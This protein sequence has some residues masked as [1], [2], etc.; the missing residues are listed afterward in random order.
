M[1]RVLESKS[2]AVTGRGSGMAARETPSCGSG[3]I[4]GL[5]TFMAMAQ[6]PSGMTCARRPAGARKPAS[7]TGAPRKTEPR[8]GRSRARFTLLLPVLALLLGGLFLLAAPPAA[9]QRTVP[10]VPQNV[11][12]AVSDTAL[13]LTWQAPSS[14]GSF[15]AAGYEID[16]AEGASPPAHSS[17]DWKPRTLSVAAAATKYILTNRPYGTKYHMRIRAISANPGDPSDTLPSD[18]VVRSGTP[19][20]THGPHPGKPTLTLVTSGT[21]AQTATTLSFTVPCVPP[22]RAPVTDYVLRA[23]RTGS[24]ALTQIFTVPSPCHTITATLTGLENGTTY[25][26]RAFARNLRA[27]N[28]AWS[29]YVQ[30]TTLAL[31]RGGGG[32]SDPEPTDPLTASFEQVPSEHDG[33][34]A[35]SVL[36]RLSE[37]VGNFSKSPRASSFEVTQ[38]RV[39]S[40]KQVDAGL[41]RVRVKPSSWRAVTV[42]LAGGRDCDD[43]G[44]V[45]TRDG[46]ALT[47]T[48]SATVGDPVRIRL[49]GGRAREGRDAALGFAVTL[50]RAAAETVSVDYATADGTAV[51]GADYTAASGTLTFAP[52][53]T[54]KTVAVAILDDA[55]DEGKEKFYFRLSNPQGAHLRNMHREATGTVRNDD[56][57]QAM[58][59]S[60]FGRMVASDAVAALTARFETPRA[61]GSHLTMLGQRVNLSQDGDGDGSQAGAKALA[62]VLTGLAQ[63]FGAPNAPVGVDDD[64]FRRHGLSNSWSG[65]APTVAG[66][67]RVTGRD[68]LLGTSF[69]AVLPSGAGS[70]F[71]SW[72]QGASV[73]QFSAAVPG[74]GL[75]GET[76]TGSLGFDYEHGR[77]LTGLAMTHSVGEGTAH[78]GQWRYAMGSTVTTMLPFA[79]L[80]LS[81][82][83]SAWAMAGTGSGSLTLDLNGGVPQR[84]GTDLSMTLA[85]TGVRGELVKPAEAG[86]FA[87]ALKADA[88]WVRTESDRVSASGFGNL[89]AARG[90]SSRMRA[91]V[92]G[93]RTFALTGGA[94]LAPS[95]ELGL[96]HDGGDAETGTGMEFGAGLG[97]A[98]PSRGLDMAL[99]VHGLAMHAEDSYDEWRVSGQLRLVPGGA[100]RG[101]SASLTPSYGV[102]PGGSERLWALPDGSRLTANGEAAPSSRLDAEMGYGMALFGDRF[103]GTPHVGFGLSDT[104]REYRMG[105]RLTSAVRGDPGFEVSLDATRREAANAGEPA[106]HGVMLRSQIRW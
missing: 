14:W 80:A 75:T 43:A 94:T 81:E 77:L 97:Y 92:D 56:P 86:G 104:A 70:Q 42:A 95:V 102:D 52:G 67:R 68:L 5:V 10:S 25:R 9:A 13:K 58:W 2:S 87:L 38:G 31:L 65:P 64:P 21:N 33:K 11:Q 28:S 16:W 106:E 53:E 89:A 45:C 69:R 71:T 100:G 34:G 76:A 73:S 39:R 83:L 62:G 47:N 26:V 98:D 55:I 90:E 72:G 27:R 61:A 37:T 22:G 59:L 8:P 48:V 20:H 50:S 15:P 105:W 41:W 4:A 60:R 40:V 93:S 103:T 84:Y 1:L 63:A 101:L 66:A 35:F 88:F 32:S 79:R 7:S 57:L 24:S 12:V 96:R 3:L 49:K 6:R 78:D 91:V 44:A 74:L 46:R 54:A 85:A 99:R 23:E 82:R 17:S 36:L 30:G 29:D 18:W 19:T 51:A